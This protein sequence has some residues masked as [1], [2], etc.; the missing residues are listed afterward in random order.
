MSLTALEEAAAGLTSDTGCL[1]GL[2][3]Q[4]AHNAAGAKMTL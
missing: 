2:L 4:A 1:G 3:L